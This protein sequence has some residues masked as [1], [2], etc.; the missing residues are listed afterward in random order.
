MYLI[1][2]IVYYCSLIVYQFSHFLKLDYP[3]LQWLQWSKAV[4]KPVIC[5]QKKDGLFD[6]FG[7][8]TISDDDYVRN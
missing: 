4:F 2:V 7:K 3:N 1:F 5:V 6:S 8:E